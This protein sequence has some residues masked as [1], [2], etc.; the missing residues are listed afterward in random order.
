M[1]LGLLNVKSRWKGNQKTS[2]P[3]FQSHITKESISASKSTS[4]V[5]CSLDTKH[6]HQK[7]RES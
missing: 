7:V 6:S 1:A 5:P 2:S 3:I 4:L